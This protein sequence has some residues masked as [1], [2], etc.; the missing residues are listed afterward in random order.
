MAKIYISEYAAM[1]K[2]WAHPDQI[3]APQEPCD[4]DQAPLAIGGVSAQSAAF[5]L[6]VRLVRVHTDAIC[7][8]A[9]GA[10]PTATTNNKR[11]AAGATEYFGV[12]PGHRLAC[13]TNT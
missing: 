9:F 2:A 6:G 12:T 3:A 4:S 7:S 10:D 5:G 1:A 13:I 8:I 11:M